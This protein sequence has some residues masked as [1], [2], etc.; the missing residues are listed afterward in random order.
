[1]QKVPL[2]A[3]MSLSPNIKESTFRKL[4]LDQQGIGSKAIN[5]GTVE[6]L[7]GQGLEAIGMQCVTGG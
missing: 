2:F 7:R 6:L 1:M 4:L 5:S 3:I